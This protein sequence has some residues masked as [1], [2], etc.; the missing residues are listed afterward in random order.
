MRRLTNDPEAFHQIA[1]SFSRLWGAGC[2]PAHLLLFAYDPDQDGGEGQ[3]GRHEK[4]GRICTRSLR[5]P[6]CEKSPSDTSDNAAASQDREQALRFTCGPYKIGQCP[7]L[8]HH[9]NSANSDPHVEGGSQPCPFVEMKAPPEWAW[10]AAAFYVRSEEHTSE[11]QSPCNLVCR[12]L[13]EKKKE[14]RNEC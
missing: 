10:L 14:L 6:F 7:N 8:S 9:Q 12:L 3:K 11:L 1:R 4:Q 2:A 5:D 13:L